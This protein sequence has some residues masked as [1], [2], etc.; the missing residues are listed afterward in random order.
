MNYVNEVRL[1]YQ[2]KPDQNN[3]AQRLPCISLSVKE[4]MM[5]V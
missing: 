3:L 4:E 5:T 2:I 1:E